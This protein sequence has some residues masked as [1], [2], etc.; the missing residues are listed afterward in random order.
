MLIM[1]VDAVMIE[2]KDKTCQATLA[3]FSLR[4]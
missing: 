4:Q 2:Q 3:G 1:F